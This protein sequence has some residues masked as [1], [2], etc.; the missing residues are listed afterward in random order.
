MVFCIVPLKEEQ[1][2]TGSVRGVSMETLKQSVQYI[3]GG[4]KRAQKIKQAGNKD[5]V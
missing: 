5:I 3:K 1:D 4:P 2:T